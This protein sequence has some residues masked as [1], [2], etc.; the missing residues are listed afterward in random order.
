MNEC[1]VFGEGGLDFG[2]PSPPGPVAGAGPGARARHRKSSLALR[3]TVHVTRH[4]PACPLATRTALSVSYSSVRCLSLLYSCRLQMCWWGARTLGVGRRGAAEP[5]AFRFG[6]GG[7][8]VSVSTVRFTVSA[9][10]Y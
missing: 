2:L 8:T 3:P 10:L 1:V 9:F 5:S 4:R 7:V 6:S